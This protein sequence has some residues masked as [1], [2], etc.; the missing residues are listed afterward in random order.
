[1]R[2]S[3]IITVNDAGSALPGSGIVSPM[4]KV[5]LRRGVVAG[6]L[7]AAT[8]V[9]AMATGDLWVRA[10]ARGHV[11]TVAEVPAAPVALVL[12]AQVYPG[13]VPSPFLAA[14]LEIA[15]QLLAAGKV[16]AILVSGDHM[17]WG[18]NEQIGRAHV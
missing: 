13:G 18:Y 3:V 8:A 2:S 6:A 12:G 15:R 14:R 16:L 17:D 5:W 1:M 7:T 11:Y 9:L 10:E 4:F